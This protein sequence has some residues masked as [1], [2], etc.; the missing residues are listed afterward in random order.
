MFRNNICFYVLY[1]DCKSSNAFCNLIMKAVRLPV[2]LFCAEL[3]AKFSSWCQPYSSSWQKK[4]NLFLW[5]TS[6][7]LK[8]CVLSVSLKVAIR[9]VRW[10]PHSTVRYCEH[11][12]WRRRVQAR[13]NFR[14]I[15]FVL[16]IWPGSAR[17]SGVSY[18]NAGSELWLM[19]SR[20]VQHV[21]SHLIEIWI[22][23][24]SFLINVCTKSAFSTSS[25]SEEMLIGMRIYPRVI[26]KEIKFSVETLVIMQDHLGSRPR[27]PRRES[28]IEFSAT[29][30][31]CWNNFE[32]YLL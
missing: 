11:S 22:F 20:V 23:K 32:R 29:I 13:Q 9:E 21:V 31:Y 12:P 27:R 5:A 2:T 3:H 4:T 16:L 15:M 7:C 30:K 25:S 1:H 14:Y 26:H 8:K 17:R 6:I 19:K 10:F 18:C 24:F 28:S